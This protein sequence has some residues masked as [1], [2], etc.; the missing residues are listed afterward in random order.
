MLVFYILLIVL[1]FVMVYMFTRKHKKL[2]TGMPQ[3]SCPFGNPGG[4]WSSSC[5]GYW[6]KD[7]YDGT[8]TL[9][10]QCENGNIFGEGY[11]FVVYKQGD[12]VQ[13]IQGCLQNNGQ[14][15]CCSWFNTCGV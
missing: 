9:Y 13:N 8:C 2:F 14:T 6:N 10:G 7:N 3:N 1:L 15:G 11:T 4:D 5:S 12:T